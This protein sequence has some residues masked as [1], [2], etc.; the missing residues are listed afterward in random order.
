[1]RVRCWVALILFLVPSVLEGQSR[2]GASQMQLEQMANRFAP[3]PL[4]VGLSSLSPGDRQA[5]VKL[6]QAA[7]I[8]ILESHRIEVAIGPH[9]HSQASPVQQIR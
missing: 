9:E 6:I 7:R 2:T 1:M 5:L 3:T 4:R 8:G